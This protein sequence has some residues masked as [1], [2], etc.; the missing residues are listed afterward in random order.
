MISISQLLISRITNMKNKNSELNSSSRFV[1]L[2]PAEKADPEERIIASAITGKY[3]VEE[4]ATMN[5]RYAIRNMG[6]ILSIFFAV[7]LIQCLGC[8]S[9]TDQQRLAEYA[10]RISAGDSLAYLERATLFYSQ[11]RDLNALDD[12]NEFIRTGATNEEAFLERALVL[13]RLQAYDYAALD[14]SQCMALGAWKRQ[15]LRGLCYLNAKEYDLAIS[16]FRS[17]IKRAEE[18]PR[19]TAGDVAYNLLA[20]SLFATGKY[21][22]AFQ[23][24]QKMDKQSF[25]EEKEMITALSGL[26][27]F[28]SA[29]R[30]IDS[31]WADSSKPWTRWSDVYY[32]HGVLNAKL[33]KDAEARVDLDSAISK[34]SS[35]ALAHVA[36]SVICETS[37]DTLG[38]NAHLDKSI[39]RGFLFGD[40]LRSQPRLFKRYSQKVEPVKERLARKVLDEALKRGKILFD[41]QAKVAREWMLATFAEPKYAAQYASLYGSIN[42]W[43]EDRLAYTVGSYTYP[44]LQPEELIKRMEKTA[45]GPS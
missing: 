8:G 31:L 28:L 35:F 42:V 11:E 43:Q 45:S 37:G 14:F 4:R 16:D 7:L 13:S 20:Q 25:E 5:N 19:D 29:R 33:G 1:Q 41:Y 17:Y 24:W 6:S 39:E 22:E 26:G 34:D 10:K 44:Y 15:L 30:F 36:F 12:L 21:V 27:D 23:E 2:P 9:P 3:N 18:S 40:L 38:A 32:M